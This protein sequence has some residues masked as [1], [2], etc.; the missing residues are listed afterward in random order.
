MSPYG[1]P[2]PGPPTSGL[3]SAMGDIALH[4][5]GRR[6][7]AVMAHDERAAGPIARQK[8]KEEKWKQKLAGKQTLWDMSSQLLADVGT[9]DDGGAPGASSELWTLVRGRVEAQAQLKSISGWRSSAMDDF[10]ENGVD[11]KQVGLAAGKQAKRR[12]EARPLQCESA[13]MTRSAPAELIRLPRR[14]AR[15][16]AGHEALSPG[17]ALRPRLPPLRRPGGQLDQVQELH[18]SCAEACEAM[19]RVIS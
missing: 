9:A 1:R 17:L 8:A 18:K 15:P 12:V 4:T 19:D 7:D 11:G 2:S 3:S 14:I 13:R 6:I 16:R 5:G 10:L